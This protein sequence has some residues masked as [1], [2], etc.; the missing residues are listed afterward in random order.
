MK[1]P[2][3]YEI[4]KIELYNGEDDGEFLLHSNPQR[5][6]FVYRPCAKWATDVFELDTMI[7]APKPLFSAR[8]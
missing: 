8:L 1:K 6:A 2:K 5:S 7:T 3:K 4:E